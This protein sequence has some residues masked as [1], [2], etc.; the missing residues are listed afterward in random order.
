MDILTKDIDEHP[1]SGIRCVGYLG[2]LEGA[3]LDRAGGCAGHII[4][5]RDRE[6]RAACCERRVRRGILG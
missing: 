4:E 3:P 6:R 1:H 5:R 2:E